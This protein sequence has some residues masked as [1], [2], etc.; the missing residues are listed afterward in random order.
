MIPDS[1]AFCLLE[2]RDLSE[3]GLR[4]AMASLRAHYPNVPIAAHRPNASAD[5][6]AW[7]ALLVNVTV[8]TQPLD[9]A[10][11]WNCKP[12]ALLNTMRLFGVTRVMWIDSDMM[13]ARPFDYLLGSDDEIVVAQEALS[14]PNQGG[15][16]RAEGWGFDCA[17]DFGCSINS[18]LLYVTT[19]HMQLLHHWIALLG[20]PAYVASQGKTFD[21]RP[22]SHLGDQDVLQA[23][24]CSVEHA[25]IPIRFIHS[26]TEVIHSGG[27]LGYALRDRLRGLTRRMPPFVHAIGTKPWW[28]LYADHRSKYRNWRAVYRR[29]LVEASPYMLLARRYKD[30]IDLQA[31][32]L[33]FSSPEGMALR[34]IALGHYALQAWPLCAGATAIA[35]LTRRSKPRARH[36]RGAAES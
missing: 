33:D 10:S 27:A 34:T 7:A 28:C 2:D 3:G 36:T 32:W 13:L 22:I 15:C 19:R 1:F 25:H 6:I 8:V 26:G 20:S 31:E 5:F 12:H 16:D 21:Q 17:R 35:A 4:L 11:S 18:S 29:L 24:L 14:Q 30:R 23:L 9:G